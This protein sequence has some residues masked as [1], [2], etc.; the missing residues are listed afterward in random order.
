MPNLKIWNLMHSSEHCIWIPCIISKS[1]R[2]WSFQISDSGLGITQPILYSVLYH[3][4]SCHIISHTMLCIYIVLYIYVAVPYRE[5]K[6]QRKTLDFSRCV[7]FLAFPVYKVM[8]VGCCILAWSPHLLFMFLSHYQL[9]SVQQILSWYVPGPRNW[10]I[11]L[12]HFTYECRRNC[13]R[14]SF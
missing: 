1:F 13:D 3:I 5:M 12:G 9:N 7:D 6:S 11:H 8:L 2:F 10:W 14:L 4:P